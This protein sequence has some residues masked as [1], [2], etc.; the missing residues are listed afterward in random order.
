MTLIH[1]ICT[2][3]F[4]NKGMQY[5]LVHLKKKREKKLGIDTWDESTK[6]NYSI[7]IKGASG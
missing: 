5:W 2:Y 4:K 7:T 3:S 1:V 6:C